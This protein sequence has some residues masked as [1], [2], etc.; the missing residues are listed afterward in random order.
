MKNIISKKYITDALYKYFYNDKNMVMLVSDSGY[1]VLDKYYMD[2]PNRVFNLG[3]A[4]QATVGISAGMSLTDL[5][6][7]IFAPIPFI[8]MRAYEQIRYDI[9][10]HNLNVKIIGSAAN[11]ALSSLGRSH[12]MDDDDIKLVSILEN[13]LILT[14]TKDNIEKSVRQ[15]I[16]YNGP[17][18]I[19]CN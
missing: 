12:C 5:H 3:I 13:F 1:A 14:P 11:N 8:I 18:Y 16:E 10:E 2:F 19:R 15:F 9:N 6:P 17:A 7:I 4:E